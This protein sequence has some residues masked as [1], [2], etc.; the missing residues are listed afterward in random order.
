MKKHTTDV[1][2]TSL[3]KNY[4]LEHTTD[5]VQTSSEN[6]IVYSRLKYF[7]HTTDV[8]RTSSVKITLYI[9]G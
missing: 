3:V 8:V 7:G 5:V 4:I 1:I 2:L 6:Y 9:Q